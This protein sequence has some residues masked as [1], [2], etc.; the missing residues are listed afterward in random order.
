M[1]DL[2]E[3][4]LGYSEPIKQP[5]LWPVCVWVLQPPTQHT[6]EGTDCGSSYSVFDEYCGA[7]LRDCARYKAKRRSTIWIPADR[8]GIIHA[9][10]LQGEL[11]SIHSQSLNTSHWS[12]L[13]THWTVS[14]ITLSCV[15]TDSWPHICTMWLH[16]D[17]TAH[18]K[19]CFSELVARADTYRRSQLLKQW[20]I[21]CSRADPPY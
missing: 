18:L 10:L 21:N 16:K 19:F 17:P 1:F 5:H 15:S 13:L 2:S 9:L 11:S 14:F 3:V 4:R 7:S 8:A 6:Q 12:D 20:A